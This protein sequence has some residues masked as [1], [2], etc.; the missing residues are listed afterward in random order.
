M[1]PADF[2]AIWPLDHH[3]F[4][5][6]RSALIRAN[7]ERAPEYAW[8]AFKGS[9]IDGFS[10][11]RHGHDCEHL[12]PVVSQDEGIARELVSTCLALQEKRPFLID[13]P[14]SS[15]EWIEWLESKGFAAERPFK[16]MFRGENRYPGEPDRQFAVFGP[17]FG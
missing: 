16:R 4:G 1:T 5:A 17:E 9:R 8:V 10:L 15:R 12:G 2:A 3:V 7:F 11:G 13:A 14:R 6:D